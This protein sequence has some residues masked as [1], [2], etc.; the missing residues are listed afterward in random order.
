VFCSNCGSE[1]EEGAVFCGKCGHKVETEPVVAETEVKAEPET[2]VKAEPEAEVKAEP[3]AEVKAEAETE[4]KTVVAP[5][6]TV[7]QQPA[8]TPKKEKKKGMGFLIALLIAL[9][10]AVA[11][12]GIW[13]FLESQKKIDVDLTGIVSFEVEG[14]SGY[15]AASLRIDEEA[16]EEEYGDLLYE[17][18]EMKMSTFIKRTDLLEY[19]V[20]SLDKLSNGD[21]IV[22]SWKSDVE[23]ALEEYKVNIICTDVEYVVSGLQEIEQINP[24]DMLS[25]Q[26][27]GISGKA[28]VYTTLESMPEYMYYFPYTVE[29]NTYLSNGDTV[30]IT[31]DN[32]SKDTVAANYGISLSE[33]QKSYVVS[34]LPEYVWDNA[35]MT[36]EEVEY[37][38]YDAEMHFKDYMDSEWA[39]AASIKNLKCVGHFI[40]KAND[41]YASVQNAIGLIYEVTANLCYEGRSEDFVYYYPVLFPNV[42]VMSDGTLDYDSDDICRTYNTFTRGF[43]PVDENDVDVPTNTWYYYGYETKD[44]LLQAYMSYTLN[45]DNLSTIATAETDYTQQVDGDK[46]ENRAKQAEE[47]KNGDI[48]DIVENAVDVFLKSTA[49]WSDAVSINSVKCAETVLCTGDV[50]SD[51]F[52][53][54]VYAVVLEVNAR[55]EY[56]EMSEDFTYYFIVRYWNAGAGFGSVTAPFENH[57]ESIHVFEKMLGDSEIWEA[58]QVKPSN[59]WSFYGYETLDEVHAKVQEMYSKHVYYRGEVIP[60]TPAEEE[61]TTGIMTEAWTKADASAVTQKAEE[62]FRAT[63][64][65]WLETAT[66]NSIEVAETFIG[67]ADIPQG[68]N[69]SGTLFGVLLKINAHV[70]CDDMAEDFDYYYCVMYDNAVV[71]EDGTVWVD[72]ATQQA[73]TDTFNKML[74]D[75][76]IWKGWELYPSN[77]W[78]FTGYATLEEAQNDIAAIQ[79]NHLRYTTEVIPQAVTE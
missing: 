54:N 18:A 8:E 40:S 6:A 7:A 47:I 60:Y 41:S 68:G 10:L 19:E 15:G 25:V 16:L 9:F 61:E 24:F 33:T 52:D 38:M 75:K 77:V 11:A 59:V 31:F 53:D 43:T 70:V 64:G 48:S 50:L 29:G 39:D 67:A 2:E 28:S 4:A 22:L 66:I 20:T 65:T 14:Y 49:N 56:K 3:E 5:E 17:H 12:A 1:M 37:L 36:L 73:S 58:W 32:S 72:E 63:T 55:M 23:K 78:V 21:K 30:T 62:V 74:G 42:M 44:E 46:I 51:A 35:Q 57:D 27:E 71:K 26:F 34:E 79:Y 13:F 76:E 69:L 45:W